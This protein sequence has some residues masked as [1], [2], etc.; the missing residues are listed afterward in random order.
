MTD[1]LF[2]GP[3]E[4]PDDRARRPSRLRV[5]IT[6][7]AAPNPSA[8]YGETVC[9][10]GLRLDAG[11]EGWVRLF[12]I[13]FR[14][15]EQDHAFRKYDVVSLDATPA[16]EGRYES[17]KP[18]IDSLHVETHLD[19]WPKRM[20]HLGPFAHATMCDL[21]EHALDGGPSLGLVQARCVQGLI[22]KEHPGWTPDEQQKISDFVGQPEL[23]DL[24]KPKTAL[25]APRFIAHY[26][27][28][29]PAL[30]CKGHEQQLLDWEFAAFQRRLPVDPTRAKEAIRRRWF[31][32]ICSPSK[33]VYFYVGNQAKRRQTFSILGVV[34]PAR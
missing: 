6:V 3:T 4:P 2:G 22:V 5:L 23:F 28:R 15:I 30:V 25:E 24:G 19:G 8:T 18:R 29:C 20:S 33:Q 16:T 14:F 11:H 17:W 32:E 9:V 34:Y 21:R 7:K 26:R 31:E 13:N 12:P 1:V 27:W 10:A